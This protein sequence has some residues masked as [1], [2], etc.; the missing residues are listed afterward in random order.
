VSATIDPSLTFENFVVGQENRLACE[1]ARTAAESPG[2]AYNPL[3]IYSDTGLGK[4]HLLIALA[5]H[6]QKMQPELQVA[7]APLEEL[8][9]TLSSIGDSDSS[10]RD[11]DILLVDDLQFIGSHSQSHQILFHLLDHL[12]MAGKQ[13]ALACDRPPLELGE[14][15]DRLLSRFSGGLVVDIGRPTLETRRAI[16]DLRLSAIGEV[17]RPEVVEAIARRA[18]ENVRQL[19]GALNRVLAAQKLEEREVEADEVDRLLADVVADSDMP[20][21]ADAAQR[22]G[23]EFEDFLTDVSSAVENALGSPKWREDLARAILKWEGEGYVTSRLESY[24]EGDETVDAEQVVAAYER[25]VATLRSIEE[26]LRRLDAEIPNG[27][28]SLRDP[29]QI[30]Q[31][32]QLLEDVRRTSLAVDD[33]FFDKEKVVWDWPVIEEQL[34]EGWG[35]GH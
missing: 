6:A 21:L 1:A 14:L 10:Y 15:D 11:A 26:E 3:F 28:L 8:M 18:I 24:L 5:N 34:M 30:A 25:D 2:S 22:T 20:W 16:L 13:V 19:K 7:Y 23:A 33:F 17:L 29:E 35:D 9:R 27:G 32:R 4:T 31:A 12:L